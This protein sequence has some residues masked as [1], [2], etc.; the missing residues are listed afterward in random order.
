[1]DS[2]G[3]LLQQKNLQEPEE[4]VAIKQFI[5]STFHTSA[6]VTVK[7]STI[8][9]TASS[10]SLA[11]ALQLQTV[12]IQRLIRDKKKLIFRIGG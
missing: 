6:A 1:M 5:E 10:A 4:V 3:K 11:N 9:I 8:I 12:A 2:I 7:T